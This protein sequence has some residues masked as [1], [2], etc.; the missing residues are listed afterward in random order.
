MFHYADENV[1]SPFKTLRI[2]DYY[3]FDICSSIS[4]SKIYSLKNT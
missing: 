3:F 1:Q 2:L 4:I